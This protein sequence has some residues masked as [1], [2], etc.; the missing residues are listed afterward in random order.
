[1]A[2]VSHPFGFPL[3]MF[4]AWSPA[5]SS[6]WRRKLPDPVTVGPPSADSCSDAK[7][8]S[9]KFRIHS[10]KRSRVADLV[11]GRARDNVL[12][13]RIQRF[14]HVGVTVADLEGVIAFFVA[15]GFEVEG[16]T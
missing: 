4:P 9:S 1:M 12:M 10:G 15:L 2:H 14:D 8:R 3:K 11:R 5:W 6:R 7:C 16:R 13:S